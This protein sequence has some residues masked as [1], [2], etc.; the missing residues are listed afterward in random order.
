SWDMLR[1]SAKFV[2]QWSKMMEPGSGRQKFEQSQEQ[3]ER[4]LFH[5][6]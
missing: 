2:S 6:G 5:G 4:D 1:I 3:E